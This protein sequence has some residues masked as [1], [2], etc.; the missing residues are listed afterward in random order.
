MAKEIC[1]KLTL[2]IVAFVLL[3]DQGAATATGRKNLT[4]LEI[5]KQLRRLNKPA[6]K[7]IKVVP[8]V[9]SYGIFF[10][11]FQQAHLLSLG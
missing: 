4:D 6:I 11:C 9:L 5:R 1:E 3:S 2:V 8:L 7:I 10:H